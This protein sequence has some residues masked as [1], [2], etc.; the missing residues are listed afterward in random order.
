MNEFEQIQ[1]EA[2][3][4]NAFVLMG[5]DWTLITAEKHGRINT[6]TASWGGFGTMFNKNVAY[7]VI[8]PHRYTREFVDHADRFSLSFFAKSFKRQMGYIGAVSGR[9]E[10]KIG[11]SGL[12]VQHDGETPYF[13]EAKLVMI[14]RKLYVQ[15]FEERFFVDQSLEPKHYPAKDHHTLYIAEVEKVLRAYR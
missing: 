12:T 5:T 4:Q 2:V 13:A 11:K 3:E 1:P 9:D 6:M 10:D 15:P 8:R 14:C 7:I